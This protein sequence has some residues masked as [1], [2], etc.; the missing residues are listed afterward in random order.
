ML[1]LLLLKVLL[2][3]MRMKKVVA[4]AIGFAVGI[5]VGVVGRSFREFGLG[6]GLRPIRHQVSQARRIASKTE[7]NKN[8]SSKLSA[9][10]SN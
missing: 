8:D 4:V 7:K 9:T 1:L 3:V 6:F 10:I 2:V 5:A